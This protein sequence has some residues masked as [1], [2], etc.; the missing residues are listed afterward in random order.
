VSECN[1]KLVS[2]SAHDIALSIYHLHHGFKIVAG[3]LCGGQPFLPSRLLCLP[4]RLG[5]R[6]LFRSVREWG[7]LQSHSKSFH[8]LRKAKEKESKECFRA[9]IDRLKRTRNEAGDRAGDK[10]RPLPRS[11]ISRPTFWM[12]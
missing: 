9:V 12:R 4:G 8:S 5:Q 3:H 2:P 6:T 11:R 1:L 10:D 7:R